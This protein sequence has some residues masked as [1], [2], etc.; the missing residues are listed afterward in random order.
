MKNE[1][2]DE[3][4]AIYSPDGLRLL[5]GPN[6]EQYHIRQGTKIICDGAF[7]G[8]ESLENITIPDSVTHIGDNAFVGCES[9]SSI[10]IP[11]SSRSKFERLLPNDLHKKLKEQ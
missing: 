2:M 5:K 7:E 9:L 8:C 1:V 10:I 6:E 11:R 4:G 3:F